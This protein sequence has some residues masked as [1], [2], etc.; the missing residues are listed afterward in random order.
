MDVDAMKPGIDFAEQLDS[1]VSQCRV[2][3]AV[4]GPRWSDAKDQAGHRRPWPKADMGGS[5]LLPCKLTPEP[6]FAGRKSLL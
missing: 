2:V 6:R 4:I 5:G 1:Q 3:L